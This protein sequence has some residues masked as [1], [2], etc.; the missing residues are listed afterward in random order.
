M[1]YEQAC[2]ICTDWEAL[3]IGLCSIGSEYPKPGVLQLCQ[4]RAPGTV[5][6]DLAYLFDP[7]QRVQ[8]LDRRRQEVELGCGIGRGATYL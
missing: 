3:T 4:T 6:V 2:T 1:Q 7:C 5:D 8:V